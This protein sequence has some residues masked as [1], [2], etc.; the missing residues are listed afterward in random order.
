M[1]DSISAD[2]ER[3][4]AAHLGP[5]FRWFHQNPELSFAEHN[6]ARRAAA[7]LRAIG[8]EVTEGVGGTGI[9]GVLRNGDG[10]TL[11]I[12]ADMD[13]L[14]VKEETGLPYAS[15]VRQR[16]QNGV[17]QPVMHSC[18]H[19]IHITSLIGT[20]R[21]LVSL[22]DRWKGTIVFV[23]QPAEE[24]LGGARAML[25][26]G[27]Y[28]RFP[29][30]DY[31]IGFHVGA[32]VPAGKIVVEQGVRH[33]TSDTIDIIVHGI[34]THGA[35]PHRGKDPITMGAEIVIALQVMI[36]RE[37]DPLQPAVITVGSFHAG[38]VRNIIPDEARLLLTLRTDSQIVREQL[39]AGIRRVAE[40]V[41]RLNGMPDGKLPT[42]I[43]HEDASTTVTLNDQ[44]LTDRLKAALTRHIGPDIFYPSY[45]E[46]LGAEDFALYIKP[47]TS[48]PGVYFRVGGTPQRDIDAAKN[49]GP[50]VAAHHSP[51][52]KVDPEAAIRLGVEAEVVSALELLK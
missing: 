48:V 36:A 7:E 22:R 8:I 45:R 28:T 40:N 2:I 38:T 4:Y 29:E 17:E 11:L 12:R 35:A 24:V 41:G 5:L 15:T 1:A 20:A 31:A 33:A 25:N 32:N 6:T 19:D 23:G 34:G 42:V 52:F 51:L 13:A 43:V 18:G 26:D 9:V 49:G 3:D 39:I 27:L 37:V 46:G 10:P 14:P 44:Q 47:S 50:R 21:R 30:P 16:D